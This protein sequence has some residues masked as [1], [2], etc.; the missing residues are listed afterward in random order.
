ME[1]TFVPPPAMEDNVMVYPG[2]MNP[3]QENSQYMGATLQTTQFSPHP[4]RS[5]SRQNSPKQWHQDVFVQSAHP[6]GQ[7]VPPY[8]QRESDPNIHMVAYSGGGQDFQPLKTVP[9][10]YAGHTYPV[11][12]GLTDPAFDQQSIIRQEDPPMSIPYDNRPLQGS[13]YMEDTQHAPYQPRTQYIP[14][15]ASALN[16]ESRVNSAE[17]LGGSASYYQTAPEPAHALVPESYLRSSEILQAPPLIPQAS[18]THHSSPPLPSRELEPVV[19]SHM[20]S[21]APIFQQQNPYMVKAQPSTVP[22]PEDIRAFAEG[23]PSLQQQQVQH[24]ESLTSSTSPGGGRQIVRSESLRL[25]GS[26][27]GPN[28]RMSPLAYEGNVMTAS[29]PPPPS[30]GG[31][32]VFSGLDPAPPVDP[33]Q[34]HDQGQISPAPSLA[35]EGKVDER[36]ALP[37]QMTASFESAHTTQPQDFYSHQTDHNAKV[38]GLNVMNPDP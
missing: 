22:A 1:Q 5:N 15:S 12:G 6:Q 34:P 30:D 7:V 38:R 29:S 33:Q 17:E 11:S 2:S 18:W 27:Q 10:S 19:M 4:S 21:S 23:E 20:E 35:E 26:S 36:E 32:E 9:L 8:D 37:P 28:Y 13:I 31:V 24:S 16:N 25:S 3:R 14:A